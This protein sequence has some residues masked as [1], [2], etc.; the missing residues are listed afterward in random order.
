MSG[1]TDAWIK[2]VHDQKIAHGGNPVM[3]WMVSCLELRTDTNGNVMPSKPD[4]KK[5]G[6]RIDGC[7]AAI[8]SLDRAMRSGGGVSVYEVRGVIAG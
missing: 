2:A 8:L 1:P 4:R 3:D 5:S 6:K 7:V